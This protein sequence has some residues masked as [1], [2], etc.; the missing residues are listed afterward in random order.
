[1]FSFQ[2]Q[3]LEASQILRLLTVWPNL[4][5]V[6][7]QE[8]TPK[9]LGGGEEPSMSRRTMVYHQNIVHS[10]EGELDFRSEAFPNNTQAQRI[11]VPDSASVSCSDNN[12][13]QP[14]TN[15][16]TCSES[17]ETSDS[18]GSVSGTLIPG[19]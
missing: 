11:V 18:Q 1:M 19:I 5:S 13:Q 7:V 9:T 12:Y 8:T 4:I 17:N 3:L 10:N 16:S 15:T 6:A 14:G 2:V